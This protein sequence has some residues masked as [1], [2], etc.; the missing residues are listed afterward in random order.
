MATFFS[1]IKLFC[2]D[3][4]LILMV[5][6]S[7]LSFFMCKGSKNCALCSKKHIFAYCGRAAPA[8][9]RLAGICFL[10]VPRRF[11]RGIAHPHTAQNQT[12]KWWLLISDQQ[13]KTL[14]T[15]IPTTFITSRVIFWWLSANSALIYWLNITYQFFRIV[16][17]PLEWPYYTVI[18]T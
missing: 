4:W 3:G 5:W 16:L 15:F 11:Q 2:H 6:V 1:W 17:K 8:G 13:W 12:T 7:K 14:I 9:A 18:C 10:W